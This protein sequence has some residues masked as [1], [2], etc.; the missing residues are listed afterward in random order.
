MAKSQSRTRILITLK[1]KIAQKRWRDSSRWRDVR[2]AHSITK[3]FPASGPA[4]AAFATELNRTEPY[5]TD[6]LLLRTV[7][8]RHVKTVGDLNDAIKAKYRENGF[9]LTP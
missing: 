5:K 2:V 3:Y 9:E 6:H 8:V 4:V 7:H 1:Q